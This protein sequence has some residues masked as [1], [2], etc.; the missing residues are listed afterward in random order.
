MNVPYSFT[1][2]VEEPV[3]TRCGYTPAEVIQSLT[4]TLAATG[5]MSTGQVLH[6][7]ADL[8][9]SGGFNSFAR[10]IW[11][12]AL[13]HVGIASPRIFVY[14]KQ[15]TT[16]ILEMLKTLPDETAY[17]TEEFQI[18]VGELVLVT[19]DA[20]T[21]SLVPW[22]KVGPETHD[23]GWIRAIKTD[24]VTESAALRLV[25]KP[26]GDMAILRTAGSHLC[27]AITEGSVDR[28]LFWIKWL[29]EEE[30]IVHKI[31]KGASLSSIERGPAGLSSRARKDVS[32]FILA[33]YGEIYKELAAKNLVRMHEEFMCLLDLLKNPPKGLTAKRHI[34]VILTQIL[35]EVPRWKTPAAQSLI[36][37]PIYLARA[38]KTVPKF[39]QEVLKYDSP[40][41]QAELAK[42]LK[43][44][45]GVIPKPKAKEKEKGAMT[46]ME[47]FDKAME[48][49][50][51][52]R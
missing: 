14:L 23:E 46:Q 6:Y 42:A 51:G 7:T 45:S 18:R 28:A 21:R 19:R 24:P 31:Q 38:V 22:P 11:E 43:S 47:A 2:P 27:K 34:F 1:P 13:I 29:L 4:K 26:E 39:F 52:G 5:A 3:R 40:K 12:Y 48:A 32:F 15:R 37:D 8:V 50:L 41:R 33:L 49:Y 17:L 36:K 16:D 35:V 25:W 30:V 10:V 44:K 20:P 9:C